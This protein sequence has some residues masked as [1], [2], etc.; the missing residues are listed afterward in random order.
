MKFLVSFLLWFFEQ[1]IR[2]ILSAKPK[3]AR[4]TKIQMLYV[5]P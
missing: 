5:Y 4:N 3:L 1:S 2:E